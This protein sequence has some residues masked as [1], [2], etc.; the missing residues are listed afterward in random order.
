MEYQESL[1]CSVRSLELYR[2]HDFRMIVG[3]FVGVSVGNK[4]I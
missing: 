3:H 1:L 2:M 4:Y